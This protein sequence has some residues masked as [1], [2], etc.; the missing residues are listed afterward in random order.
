MPSINAGITIRR[1]SLSSARRTRTTPLFAVAV[2][3]S[4][5]RFGRRGMWPRGEEFLQQPF[6]ALR[7]GRLGHV[8]V[9]TGRNG[10]LDVIFLTPARQGNQ[11]R[12]PPPP[13]DPHAPGDLVTIEVRHADVQQYRIRLVLP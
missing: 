8:D 12:V 6:D 9:E 4:A 13:R 5:L 7:I 1:S 10:P 3:M 11:Q 2:S